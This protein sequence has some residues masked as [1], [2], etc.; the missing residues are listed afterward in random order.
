MIKLFCEHCHI[1][2]DVCDRE[3][4]CGE[5][6]EMEGLNHFKQI[7][8]HIKDSKGNRKEINVDALLRQYEGDE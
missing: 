7:E 1:I 3:F 5:C 8:I 2:V 6:S 4:S